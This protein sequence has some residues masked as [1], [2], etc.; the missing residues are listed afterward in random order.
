MIVR[1]AAEEEVTSFE[2]EGAG[3]IHPE[4]GAEAEA[5][6]VVAVKLVLAG[7]DGRARPAQDSGRRQR[8]AGRAAGDECRRIHA[9]RPPLEE[10]DRR[11]EPFVRSE[12]PALIGVGHRAVVP[13]DRP[14]VAVRAVAR[15]A[16]V[17]VA[18]GPAVAV[19]P[20]AVRPAAAR[21]AGRRRGRRGRTDCCRD[22][23][24]SG[25]RLHHVHSAGRS[26]RPRHRHVR[27]L[28]R[29]VG[30]FFTPA[31]VDGAGRRI[32]R[33]ERLVARGLPGLGYAD[34]R[35]GQPA[36]DDCAKFL[37]RHRYSPIRGIRS[38]TARRERFRG[39]TRSS[40]TSG[41]FVIPARENEGND[42]RKGSQRD[43]L[44]SA[45]PACTTSRVPSS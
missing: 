14:A 16:V 8:G 44:I 35:S 42:K 12:R 4:T 19:R 41:M 40:G 11:P 17:P 13:G 24:S 18:D 33:R 34:R 20:A 10:F 9:F 30:R 2:A 1:P 45:C 43:S 27:H 21:G 5:G 23:R 36:R 38:V 3:R 29:H 22:R 37:A 25:L 28:R 31:A 39:T 6:G 15:A 32:V 7:Q 26:T